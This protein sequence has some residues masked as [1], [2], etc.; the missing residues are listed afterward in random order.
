VPTLLLLI[1]HALTDAAG[2]TLSG[3]QRG[4][5]LNDEGRRQAEHLVE[6]LVPVRLGAVYSSS[7]ER[8]CETAAPVA[9]ARGLEVERVPNLRDVDYGDW[10]GRSMR[11]VTGTKQWRRIMR[12]PS[13]EPFPGGETLRQVQARVLN[14]IG[15]IVHDNPRA[16]VA[17]FTHADPIRLALA[18][19]GGAHIDLFQR[20]VVHPA[21]VSA[22]L[23]G[24]GVPR[25]LKVNDT[26]SLADLALPS[27]KRRT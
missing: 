13:G 9:R 23:A 2:R 22:V 5:H 4:V 20:L 24:D 1:R 15:R 19:Y 8:C 6:R 14:E 16:A 26:G 17:V 10:S 12:D 3:W 11:Q 25:I 7:L 27:P 18:H 21:S